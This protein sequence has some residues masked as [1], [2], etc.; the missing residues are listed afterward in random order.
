MATYKK[1]GHKPA[2]KKERDE[3]IEQQSAT[4]GVFNTLDESA[5]KTEKWVAKNQKHI[6][7][8]IG[9]IALGALIYM[10]YQQFISAP[11]EKE[12]AA[13]LFQAEN[14]FKAAENTTAKDSIYNL[15]L[16]GGDGKYGFLKIIENYGNTPSGNLAKYYAGMTYMNL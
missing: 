16:H 5:S 13:E 9:V 12:A 4:A 15:A 7:T 1:R 11:K 14:Y 10:G 6:F 8:F 2:N 3:A